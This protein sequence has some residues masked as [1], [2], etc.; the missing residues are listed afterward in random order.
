MNFVYF[1]YGGGYKLNR[2]DLSDVWQVSRENTTDYQHPTQKP[3]DIMKKIIQDTSENSVIL[4]PFGGS[5]T[6]AVAAK[7]LN[8]NYICI[9]KEAKYVAICH[10]RLR[11]ELLF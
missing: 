9:E 7:Q 5:C 10:E 3:M 6:T 2:H 4:D 8:R 11:Q 1:L